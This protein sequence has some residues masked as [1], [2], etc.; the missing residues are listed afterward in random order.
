MSIKRKSARALPLRGTV[1]VPGDKSISHRAL[2]LASLAEGTSWITSLNPG[3]DVGSTAQALR[4]MG[5]RVHPPSSTG[6]VKVE[7][8]GSLAEPAGVLDAGNSGSTV[9]MLAG[10]CAG[11]AGLTVLD[12]D[13]SLRRRPMLR[14]VAPLRMMG[15]RIDG[16]AHG[17]LLPMSIRGGDLVGIDHE[18]PVAS[19]QVKTALLLAGLKASG[20]TTLLEP[21][22]SR[23]H[24]ER[25]LRAA[26]VTLETSAGRVSMEGDQRPAPIDRAIPGDISSAMYLVAAA[27]LL[28]GS[29]LTIT[30]VGLNP[31][32]TGAVDVLRDM[33]GLIDT[34]AS[35]ESGGEPRGDLYVRASALTGTEVAAATVP[36]LIDEVPV[37]A[38][39]ASQSEGETV[40]RGVGE[41][42]AKESDRLA[43]MVRNLNA[44][45]GEAEASGDDLIVRGPTRL[46][47][48]EVD[49]ENDHRIALAFAIAG[50]VSASPIK[51]KRWSAIDISFPSFLDVLGT[52]RG[53]VR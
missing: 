22:V 38:V 9:R 36:G 30:D 25:M 48:G 32:R 31:T 28:E 27:L 3:A 15:S 34:D 20:R 46:S 6:E 1:T 41:L 10:V 42:R 24:T 53:A 7:G 11:V 12:G 44:L 17:E 51:I 37:L 33:G 45:G 47:G 8:S 26:G 19:A 52:A 49:S 13:A 21:G 14:V 43:A 2:I 23:D 40:F 39:V 50:L 18:L 16:R 5:A 4:L 29:E 35:D